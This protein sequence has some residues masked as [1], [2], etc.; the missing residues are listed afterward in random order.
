MT[1]P[2]PDPERI[3]LVTQELCAVDTTTGQEHRLMPLLT[4]RLGSL[5][6]RVRLQPVEGGRNNI[7]ATW[8]GPKVLFTTHLE[9][10]PPF[11]PPRREGGRLWGRG[12]C[13][14]KGI[15]A[16]LLEAIRL[17]LA[18]RARRGRGP[19][20]RPHRAGEHVPGGC[21]APAP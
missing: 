1:R 8:G 10:V 5:G 11:I 6:A 9:T 14:A 2:A 15:L 4:Q 13:D 20:F 21:A 16:T 17:L 7:L 18:H 12:T 3:T 19:D